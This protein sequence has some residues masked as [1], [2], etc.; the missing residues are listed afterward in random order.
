M[1]NLSADGVMIVYT[2]NVTNIDNVTIS[3]LHAGKTVENGPVVVTLFKS[4]TPLSHVRRRSYLISQGNIT[5]S[6][7]Q[8]QL[9]GKQISVRINLL[10][11][12][13]DVQI[14]FVNN[15]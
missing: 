4:A 5:S 15:E 1:V 7:L 3:H 11:I 12:L 13:F 9:Y 14:N 6:D 8:G 10:S 2:V